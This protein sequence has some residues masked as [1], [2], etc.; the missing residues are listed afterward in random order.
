[1]TPQ[2]KLPL[3]F[4]L[5]VL[6][7]QVSSCLED[8]CET[9]RTYTAFDP[10]YK[11]RS[12]INASVA[13][14]RSQ[15]LEQPGKIYVYDDF[16]FVNEYRKGVH[17]IDNANPADP[18][19]V[20]FI[21]IEGNVDIA[22]L[23]SVLYADNYLDLVSFD[24]SDPRRPVLINREENVFPGLGEF[25]ARGTLVYY[26]Q[27]VEQIEIP[28][29]DP[30][31]GL[32]IIRLESSDRVFANIGTNQGNAAGSIGTESGIGGSLARF[33]ISSGYL[34]SVSD[35]DLKVFS[36]KDP[37]DP[38]LLNTVPIGWGIETIFPLGEYLFIGANDG[39]YI[40]D[41]SIPS[42]PRQLS[43]FRHARACDP[44]F[45]EGDKAYVTLR[46]G[47]ICESFTNQLEVVD[48][49]DLTNPSL[50]AVYPMHHPIGLSLDDG[51]LFLC[52]DDQGLKVFDA[53]D[54]KNIDKNLLDHET[55]FTTYDVITL[56]KEKI[57]I[58][59]GADGLYQFDYSNPRD[60]KQLSLLSVYKN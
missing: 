11:T 7:F 28:C 55:G 47:T 10:V 14:E 52:E 26:E 5:L 24:I 12:E 22:V 9:T 16:I 56:P 46:D 51:I 17:I 13:I 30:N 2:T 37:R 42:A 34:Y 45:V 39:M 36:L 35:F 1:M 44:V 38:R 40:F 4:M 49:S 60:L 43:V 54:W 8:T 25:G 18:L 23:G 57:A 15:N 3:F 32:D 19:F 20:A 27:S 48:V 6:A 31:F 21:K 29:T 33:T 59:I 50:L 41:N 53:K 58:V